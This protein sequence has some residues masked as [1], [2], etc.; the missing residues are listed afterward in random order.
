MSD[1]IIRSI[2]LANKV[3]NVAGAHL[4]FDEEGECNLTKAGAEGVLGAIKRS[5]PVQVMERSP[6]HGVV[7]LT[8][9]QPDGDANPGVEVVQEDKQ[10]QPA[11]DFSFS[12]APEKADPPKEEAKKPEPPKE[13][14]KPEPP[15]E[16]PKELPKEAP[17]PE[18]KV[19]ETAPSEDAILGG[20]IPIK[21]AVPKIEL[22][23]TTKKAAAKKK[24]QARKKKAVKD[25]T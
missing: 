9:T 22:K 13:V 1:I 20:S 21:E 4:A 10:D 3:K 19:K 12:I 18:L 17:E 23:K 25:K 15:K 5:L 24:A 2:A 16:E 7:P 11:E 6:K 8:M 14:K